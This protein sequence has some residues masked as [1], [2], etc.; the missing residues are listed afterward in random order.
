MYAIRSYYD[1]SG[2]S[3]ESVGSTVEVYANGVNIGTTQVQNGGIWY[4]YGLN[5]TASYNF[6]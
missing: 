3:T 4:L 5:L 1:V 2:T 6:V